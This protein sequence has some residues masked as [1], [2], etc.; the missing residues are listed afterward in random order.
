MKYLIGWIRSD[1]I[2]NSNENYN[3]CSY[4]EFH[5]CLQELYSSLKHLLLD[6]LTY[7]DNNNN[8][9][10]NWENLAI[11]YYRLHAFCQV[12]NI[13]LEKYENE[14]EKIYSYWDQAV[15]IIIKVQNKQNNKFYRED[16]VYLQTT[17]QSWYDLLLKML[18]NIPNPSQS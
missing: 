15:A 8:F 12:N 10:D 14:I 13:L 18:Y 17:L 3:E 1:Q 5:Q 16:I 9:K 7:R 2:N 6:A 11:K 4:D